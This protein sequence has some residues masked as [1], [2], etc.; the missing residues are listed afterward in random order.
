MEYILPKS[1]SFTNHRASRSDDSCQPCCCKEEGDLERPGVPLS[2]GAV[3][4]QVTRQLALFKGSVH[5]IQEA[6]VEPR[7]RSD[8]PCSRSSRHRCSWGSPWSSDRSRRSRSTCQRHRS[9]SHERDDRRRRTVSD[10]Q[11]QDTRVSQSKAK[12]EGLTV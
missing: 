9:R 5:V 7:N 12:G 10:C 11:T 6:E 1:S 4:L 8:V 3:R 2:A